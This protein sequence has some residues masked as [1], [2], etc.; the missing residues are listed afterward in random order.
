MNAMNHSRSRGRSHSHKRKPT[1]PEKD[2]E[3]EN[4]N[5]CCSV[6]RLFGLRVVHSATGEGGEAAGCGGAITVGVRSAF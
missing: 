3:Q 4:E 2:Y 5:E 6:I 1:K